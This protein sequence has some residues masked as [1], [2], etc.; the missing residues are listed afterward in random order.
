MFRRAP[1]TRP[2][3]L[4]LGL[5]AD[6]RDRPPLGSILLANGIAA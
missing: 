6:E 2:F 5:P 4:R 1:L 3:R